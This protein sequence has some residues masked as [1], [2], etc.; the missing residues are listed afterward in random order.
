M[1]PMPILLNAP[2][3]RWNG[4]WNSLYWCCCLSCTLILSFL[5][6]FPL[7]LPV[8]LSALLPPYP[9][10]DLILLSL[11]SLFLFLCLFVFHGY[12]SGCLIIS[13]L[14]FSPHSTSL[15]LAE[16][17]WMGSICVWEHTSGNLPDYTW[18]LSVYGWTCS[19]WMRR[20]W[21]ALRITCSY[22]GIWTHYT[23]LQL[24]FCKCRFHLD[25]HYIPKFFTHMCYITFHFRYITIDNNFDHRFTEAVRN[26]AEWHM[27]CQKQ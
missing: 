8:S 14:S 15:P 7:S 4:Q 23:V 3:C 19:S 24:T 5:P 25:R 10:D 17:S 22:K 21:E 26:L 12:F 6:S 1:M 2:R 18:A 20:Y 11:Y 27:R 13:A 16:T 9:S